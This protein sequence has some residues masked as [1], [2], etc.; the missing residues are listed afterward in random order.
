MMGKLKSKTVISSEPTFPE[1]RKWYETHLHPDV[2]N[3]DDPEVYKNVYHNG[4]FPA[5]FQCIEENSQILMKDGICK[6][7]KDIQQNDEV[8]VFDEQLQKF[9]SSNVLLNIDKGVKE[10][11]EITFTTGNTLTCTADHKILTNKGWKKAVELTDN[12]MILSV[13]EQIDNRMV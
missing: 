5:I 11:I 13:G 1:I 6:S 8:I 7:L 2:N 3:Y 10:C 12:D 9:T 4:N